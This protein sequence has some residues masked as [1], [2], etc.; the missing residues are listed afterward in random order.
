MST[1]QLPETVLQFGAGRFLRAFVDRFIQQANDSGQNVGRVVVV[2]REVDGRADSMQSQDGFTVLVR[3]YENGELIE[4]PEKVASISR[5]I[6]AADDWREVLRIA[7]TT[8]LKY[9][10]S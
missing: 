3:G 2:Q 5:S 6:V 1:R 10:V 8:E 9:I 4:R 7:G